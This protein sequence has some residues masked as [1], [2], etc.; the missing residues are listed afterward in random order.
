MAWLLT[1]DYW[2]AEECAFLANWIGL[3]TNATYRGH[4][5]GL[6]VDHQQRRATAWDLRTVGWAVKW[7]PVELAESPV[8]VFSNNISALTASLSDRYGGVRVEGAKQPWFCDV[9]SM[10]SAA[11]NEGYLLAALGWHAKWAR[12]AQEIIRGLSLWPIQRHLNWPGREASPYLAAVADLE[13]KTYSIMESYRKTYVNRNGRE[14]SPD[15]Y[16]KIDH[17]ALCAARAAGTPGA[18]EALA[19]CDAAIGD[20]RWELD[21]SFGVE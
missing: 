5:K 20:A 15:Y 19:R 2:F 1:G 7:L 14:W 17:A 13:G 16:L 10:Y 21:P 3:N 18:D 8:R 6:F 11:Y 4:E 12:G 9:D